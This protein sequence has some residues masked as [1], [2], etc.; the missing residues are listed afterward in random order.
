MRH[1]AD[2]EDSVLMQRPSIIESL[3]LMVIVATL[4]P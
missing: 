2:M 1:D 4:L 3:Q